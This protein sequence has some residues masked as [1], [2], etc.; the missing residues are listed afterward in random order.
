MQQR[1]S[2]VIRVVAERLSGDSVP[3]FTSDPVLWFDG[4][5]SYLLGKS[6]LTL[7]LTDD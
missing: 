6:F 3:S 2:V 7:I 5:P 4:V 1:I